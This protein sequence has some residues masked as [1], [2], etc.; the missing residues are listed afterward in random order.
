MIVST[1]PNHHSKIILPFD[2]TQCRQ[3]QSSVSFFQTQEREAKNKMREK[4]KEL[5]RQRMEANK[6]GV[7]SPGFGGGG[8]GSNTGYSAAPAVGDSASIPADINK[9]SFTAMQ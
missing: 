9:P 3:Y 6:K 4:A 8:F 7:K 2:T 5:H 1:F